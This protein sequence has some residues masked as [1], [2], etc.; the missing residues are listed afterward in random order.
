MRPELLRAIAKT[1]LSLAE[2]EHGPERE[3]W[4]KLANDLFELAAVLDAR[5]RR[6]H[7]RLVR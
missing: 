3:S 7:L 1:T 2:K 6:G 4:T 5:R